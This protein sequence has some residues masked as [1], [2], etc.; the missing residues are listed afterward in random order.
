M[1]GT[2]I[3]Y[4]D[5][6]LYA[7]C[8]DWCNKTQQGTI[9]DKGDGYE[10]IAVPQ[11]SD[12]EKLNR[13]K[14]AKISKLKSA[15]DSEEL[16]PILYNGFMWDFDSKAQQRINGAIIALANGGTVTWTSADN[17]EIKSVNAN[18]LKGVVGTA[19]VR[20]NELHIKYR[21][22]KGQVE[23]AE[24]EDTINAVEW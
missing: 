12:E 3:N 5:M 2:K 18:D 23:A 13:A 10:V 8:A 19:A 21:K 24:T 15:R 16:S 4:N 6:N 9:A 17:I 20:S 22:L 7:Q 1:I 11:P 14:K